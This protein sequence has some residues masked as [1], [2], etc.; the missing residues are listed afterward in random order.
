MNI[1]FISTTF[2]KS[3]F[4]FQLNLSVCYLYLFSLTYIVI[5]FFILGVYLKYLIIFNSS[6]LI[7]KNK[8]I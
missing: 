6:S 1:D 5:M 2:I 3:S 4:N 7:F 8:I